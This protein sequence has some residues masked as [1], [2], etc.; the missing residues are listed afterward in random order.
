MRNRFIRAVAVLFAFTLLATA[1]NNHGGPEKDQEI[2]SIYGWR[3]VTNHGVHLLEQEVW[4]EFEAE[5]YLG[6]SNFSLS[7]KGCVVGVLRERAD[8][9]NYFT[10]TH[11]GTFTPMDPDGDRLTAVFEWP[12]DS[13]V[14][15][16]IAY[17]SWV[18]LS[19]YNSNGT[20]PLIRCEYHDPDNSNGP[21][22]QGHDA[23]G[24]ET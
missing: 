22:C 23:E 14:W 16:L 24:N 13:L 8:H 7:A 19:Y 21:D 1:C 20:A 11:C 5:R 12:H 18:D 10:H 2:T 4:M 6:S 3:G 17:E 9:N 15:E